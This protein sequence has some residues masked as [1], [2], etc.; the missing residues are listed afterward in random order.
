MIVIGLPYGYEEEDRG[1]ERRRRRER[2]RRKKRDIAVLMC[3]VS[4][5]TYK[6]NKVYAEATAEISGG[7]D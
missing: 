4:V 6:T 7:L 5:L 3:W 1:I 2:G